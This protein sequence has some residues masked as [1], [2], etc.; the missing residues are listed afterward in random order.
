M[1]GGDDKGDDDKGDDD[2]ALK[3][4]AKK[5]KDK[6]KDYDLKYDQKNNPD[7]YVKDFNKVSSRES[8]N[9]VLNDMFEPS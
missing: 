5:P 8:K 9:D 3:S 2:N 1:F 6:S 7:K 4:K